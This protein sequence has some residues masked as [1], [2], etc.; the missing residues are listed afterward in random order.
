MGYVVTAQAAMDIWVDDLIVD[1]NPL[2][3]AD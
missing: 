3:C 2:T 1:Q